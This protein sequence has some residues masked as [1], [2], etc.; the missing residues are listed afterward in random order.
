[1]NIFER[2]GFIRNYIGFKKKIA[3]VCGNQP[4]LPLIDNHKTYCIFRED[5]ITKK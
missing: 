2:R 5:T 3:T 1:L 4:E